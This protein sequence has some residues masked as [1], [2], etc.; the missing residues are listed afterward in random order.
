[1]V[2]GREVVLID[3]DVYDQVMAGLSQLRSH[4]SHLTSVIQVNPGLSHKS[5]YLTYPLSYR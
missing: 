3:V 2:D 5:K 1:M 4:L